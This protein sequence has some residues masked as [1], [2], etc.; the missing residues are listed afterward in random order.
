MVPD[1]A[2]SPRAS[3]IRSPTLAVRPPL[4]SRGDPVISL[5]R[6]NAQLITGRVRTTTS[7]CRKPTGG[8]GSFVAPVVAGELVATAG[9]YAVLF[10]FAIGL[11]VMGVLTV[12]QIAESGESPVSARVYHLYPARIIRGTFEESVPLMDS[13]QR[14]SSCRPRDTD[15]L[16]CGPDR[17]TPAATT[18]VLERR[19]RTRGS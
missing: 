4:G 5:D 11:G 12:W 15:I 19:P 9:T 13:T 14:V 17:P 8:L 1:P 16:Q 18:R 2:E 3:R 6:Y 7:R 10:V